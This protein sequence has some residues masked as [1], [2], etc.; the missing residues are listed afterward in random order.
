[1]GTHGQLNTQSAIRFAKILEKYDCLWFE[2]PVPMENVDE[3]FTLCEEGR[4]SGLFYVK[5]D[6]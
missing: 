6:G 1:M 3:L 2:E 4:D 5:L